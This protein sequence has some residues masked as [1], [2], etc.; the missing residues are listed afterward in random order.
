MEKQQTSAGQPCP[1]ALAAAQAA[2]EAVAPDTV[3]LFGSRARGDYRPDSDIDLLVLQQNHPPLVASGRANRAAREYL[4]N[5]PPTV[6]V[7]SIAI[8]RQTFLYARRAK[9]HVA[10]QALRD[11]VIMSGEKLDYTPDYDDEY[12]T[13]WPDIQ[14]RL[15]AAYRHLN[16]FEML[17]ADDRFSQEICG[18]AGQQ[19]VENAVKGW[20]SA[21]NLDYDKVHDIEA[22]VTVLLLDP[23]ESDTAA[24]DQ[25]RRLLNF[26][27][28]EYAEAPDEPQNWLTSYAV[29]YRYSGAAYRLEDPDKETFR[30]EITEAVHAFIG[31]AQELT[32]TDDHDLES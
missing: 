24:A 29:R 10:A 12:P 20:I 3:I 11:G 9:N 32:G 19:A 31:R 13:N 27:R 17:I 1:T 4:K 26:T 30:R 21:A 25:L 22:I 14:E 2:Q 23:V 28:Y 7:N 16:D 5:H 15:R 8:P 18:F 6:P